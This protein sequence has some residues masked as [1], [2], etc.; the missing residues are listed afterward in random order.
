M[1][2]KT[3]FINTVTLFQ[4]TLLNCFFHWKCQSISQ[5]YSNILLNSAPAVFIEPIY[6]SISAFIYQ[7]YLSYH[8]LGELIK[9]QWEISYNTLA[10]LFDAFENH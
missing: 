4:L 10:F 5:S 2:K 6:V 1:E 9:Y 3:L 8:I 7:W